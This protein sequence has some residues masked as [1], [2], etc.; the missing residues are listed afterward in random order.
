MSK[1]FEDCGPFLK[2]GERTLSDGSKILFL[3]Q[4][5]E[6]WVLGRGYLTRRAS[7]HYQVHLYTAY[8]FDGWEPS[9]FNAIYELPA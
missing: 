4:V 8:K 2:T 3:R 7:G 5:T 9:T 1:L 6:G